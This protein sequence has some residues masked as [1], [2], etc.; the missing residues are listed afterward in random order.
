[1]PRCGDGFIVPNK[2]TCDDGNTTSGDGCSSICQLEPG[3]TCVSPGTSCA[4]PVCGNGKVE[5]G[6]A[7]DCGADPAHLATGCVGWNGLFYGDGQGCSKT[8]TREPL[9]Q[10]ANGKTQACST[11]CGDNN[12]DPGEDCDDG[13]RLDGDGCSA[14]CKFESNFTCT[15][16]PAYDSSSCQSGTGN[17][18]ELPIIYRD[19]QPENIVPGG[20]PDFFWLGT[21]YGGATS[22]TTVCVPN[23][24]GPS[25]GADATSRCWGIV[26]DSLL[27][28][29]PQPGTTRTCDCQYS[30][31]NSSNTLRIPGGYSVAGNDSPLSDGSG[32]YLGPGIGDP[33]TTTSTAGTFSG[34]IVGYNAGLGPIFRGK[35]PSY[36]DAASF[37][38][39]FNDDASVNKTFVSVLE[40]RA[41][42]TNLYQFASQPHLAS[43]GFF[44]LDTLNPAQ[45]TL[46]NL[47]PYWNHGTG[48]PIWSVCKG[49]QYYV[50]PRVTRTDC[51]GTAPLSNGCWVTSVQGQ[52]H[53]SY[54][55]DEARYYFVY[56]GSSRFSLQFFGDDDLF[57]FINGTLVLDL[58][59]IHQQLPGKVVVTGDPGVA[60]I[61][62]GGCLDA[63]GNIQG[64]TAGA[65]S[66]WT[67]SGVPV[68][69]KTPE[70][71]RSRTLALGLV[72]G[73]VYEIA[74]FGA[75]RHPPE[76]NFQLSLNGFTTKHSVC[77]PRC[78]DR[79]ISAGEECD[80]GDANSDTTYGGCTTQCKFGSYCGD[81]IKNGP[82]E[83]DLGKNNGNQSLGK[84][85][86]SVGCTKPHYCGDG[87]V[88]A[89]LGEECD[90]GLNN[91]PG[92]A[93]S[94]ACKVLLL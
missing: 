54:F 35:A 52:K 7:C 92:S 53:D 47:W 20:H 58:G 16:T 39:W 27:H 41:V 89:I 94:A 3:A 61:T 93:C 66:C 24:S 13:N 33:I 19:F 9:C 75:D 91:G 85:G 1:M 84:D 44:P 21:R 81:G 88:D 8:C 57:V 38:Q 82:E 77:A 22:S 56:D 2:E 80:T 51:P 6:E 30:E 32:A 40:L 55:T 76:S 49:D 69:A 87:R 14:T 50:P 63:L 12:I 74:I 78:G 60:T 17:C 18:L 71:F 73:K 65:T 45:A 46:C 34:S 67:G 37:A 70:D 23:S 79:V 42:G 11:A 36:R 90:L 62:E 68:G 29:K 4:R 5:P 64:A 86:C 10:D 31:W 72:T 48:L 26:G 28:G 83:C 59:G 15:P 25:K 43:G